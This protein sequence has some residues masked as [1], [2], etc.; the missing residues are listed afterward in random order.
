MSDNISVLC[1]ECKPKQKKLCIE[2][3]CEIKALYNI[4]NE[5]RGL[6]CNIHKKEGMI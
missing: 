5:K 3:N 4:N 2:N 6:Y 1:I